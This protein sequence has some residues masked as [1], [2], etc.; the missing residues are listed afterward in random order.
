[1]LSFLVL[2]FLANFVLHF[3]LEILYISLSKF[4]DDFE[5]RYEKRGTLT[6]TFAIH[7]MCD[8]TFHTFQDL[9]L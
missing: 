6:P 5:Y 8:G 9:F 7:A 1:M 2:S 4:C 3:Y